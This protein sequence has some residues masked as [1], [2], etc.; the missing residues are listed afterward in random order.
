MSIFAQKA[1]SEGLVENP[2]QVRNDW[3]GSP[4]YDALKAESPENRPA[5]YQSFLEVILQLCRTIGFF[6]KSL[7]YGT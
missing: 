7:A 2:Q 4:H 1:L 3:F 6:L 5:M